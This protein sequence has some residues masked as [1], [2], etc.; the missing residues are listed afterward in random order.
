M[1]KELVSVITVVYNDVLN[2]E[3]TIKSVINQTY[4]NIE[5]V[6]IDGN[7]N[8]G[9]V[10]ICK[11]YENNISIFISEPDT[12]IYNAMNKG[13]SVSNGEWLFFLNSGDIFY[14]DDSVANIMN[15]VGD[16]DICYGVVVSKNNK[17]LYS[18]RKLT[19]LH[20]LMERTICH[21]AIFA[22]KTS[23]DANF[24]DENY[25]IIADRIWLYNCYQKKLKF[26]GFESKVCIYDTNGV[27]S[28]KRNFDLESLKWLKSENYLFYC[29]G[30]IKRIV[31]KFRRR[32]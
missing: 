10:S 5:Y 26:K 1:K 21:Q 32:R 7:S 25:R 24:F 20:F 18:P 4:E 9:T 22:K 29:I 17:Q 19:R 6:V 23:F 8:D 11:K 27:S 30:K 14:N 31:S 2:I 16:S 3:N 12:G 28:N 13:I 15:N